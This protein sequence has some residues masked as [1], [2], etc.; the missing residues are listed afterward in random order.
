MNSL[1]KLQLKCMHSFISSHLHGDA[2]SAKRKQNICC[3]G[4]E[5]NHVVCTGVFY[6]RHL[7][8]A[9]S[10]IHAWFLLKVFAQKST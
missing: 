2:M 9:M 3:A 1:V 5:F 7:Q 10:L 8:N 4:E 6:S